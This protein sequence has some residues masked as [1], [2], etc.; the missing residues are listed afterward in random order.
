MRRAPLARLQMS[1]GVNLD[2]SESREMSPAT[3]SPSEPELAKSGRGER[4]VATPRSDLFVIRVGKPNTE[5]VVP[6]AEKA[7]TLVSKIV[8]ATRK[9]GTNRT[10]IF[11]SSKGKTVY[12]YSVAPSD[13]T[14]IV[15][16]DAAGR[17]IVGRLVNGRF[18]A[19]SK[20]V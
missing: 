1:F 11:R 15:R 7:S 10:A 16:E 3:H 12:A 2:M 6:A 14:K 8:K 19:L 17:K 4:I 9:P 13:V 18:R 20:S 5:R